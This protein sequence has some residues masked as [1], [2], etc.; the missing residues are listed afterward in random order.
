[1]SVVVILLGLKAKIQAV[2]AVSPTLYG[3]ELLPLR[4]PASFLDSALPSR[5]RRHTDASCGRPAACAPD[6]RSKSRTG[7]P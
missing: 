2:R 1:M 6:S 5:C 7:G 4:L 3:N